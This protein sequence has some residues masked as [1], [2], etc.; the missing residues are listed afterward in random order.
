[1]AISST[2]SGIDFQFWLHIS[3]GLVFCSA[4]MVRV[5]EVSAAVGNASAF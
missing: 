2:P 3:E 1:M 4:S 5:S